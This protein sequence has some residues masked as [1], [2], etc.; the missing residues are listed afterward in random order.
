ML[1]ANQSPYSKIDVIPTTLSN[2]DRISGI[3][4]IPTRKITE[5]SGVYS[6]GKSTLGLL[7]VSSAQAQ[8]RDCLWADSEFS[9]DEKY[10]ETLGV[11][12]TQLDLLQERF[13]EDTLDAIEAWA[14]G[15]KN[16]LIVVD[17]IG[18]LLPR[19]EAEKDASGKVIGGQARLIAV[20]CR[21][22]IPLIAINNI[23]LVVLNHQRIDLMSGRLMTGGG[24]KLEYAK[25]L[26][27]SLKKL[28]KR[29]MRGDQRIGDIIEAE[30]KKNK[31]AGTLR[32]SAELNLLYGKG[33]SAEADK[34]QDLLESGRL[35][36]VGNTYFLDEAKVARSKSA[37]MEYLKEH[38]I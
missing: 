37:M 8:G 18:Q 19:Q 5:I 36:K 25:S 27:I 28:N 1:K 16:A 13:A 17:S 10:A 34:M 23:A 38:D 35:T 2:L 32:Q 30:I 4:G 20:F 6:V 26:H 31:L 33:F 3:G 21:K 9:F 29:L 11:E 12:L 7:V 24:A 22:M 15:H 14:E